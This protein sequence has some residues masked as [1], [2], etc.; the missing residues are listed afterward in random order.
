MHRRFARTSTKVKEYQY[1][2]VLSKVK[3]C[4]CSRI[5]K[6]KE[7]H[8]SRMLSRVREYLYSRI[9]SKARECHHLRQW[10]L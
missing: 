8:C 5:S 6:A 1:S 2:K 3:A 4:L 10:F 7:C 9:L